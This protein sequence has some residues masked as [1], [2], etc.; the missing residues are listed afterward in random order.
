[1]VQRRII[2][3]LVYLYLLVGCVSVPQISC[4]VGEGSSVNELMYF[5]TAKPNGAVT[6]NEWED[7]LRTSI[8]PRF[9]KGLTYWLATGQWQ[10]SDGIVV[11]EKTFVL[12][13]I[14]PEDER[15]ENAVHTIVSEYKR[16]FNQEAVLR[17]KGNVC[18]GK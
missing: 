11:Q 2:T 17:I 8:T 13:L 5:G 12:S 3:A 6:S 4:P 15:S 16:Q 9:P 10:G 7:F 18:V 14:H 1:M